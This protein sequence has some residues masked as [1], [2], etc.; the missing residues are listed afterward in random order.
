MTRLTMATLIP[1]VMFLSVELPYLC[2]LWCVMVWF[3]VS[4]YMFIYSRLLDKTL[5]ST[6]P[7]SLTLTKCNAQGMESE[8]GVKVESQHVGVAPPP[9]RLITPPTSPI[10]A[11]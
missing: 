4:L 8:D 9:A 10:V 5:Q 6:L 3:S 7:S 2:Q 11:H 1:I